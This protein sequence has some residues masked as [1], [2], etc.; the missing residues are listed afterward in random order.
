MQE[1]S[2]QII[3]GK[4]LAARVQEEVAAQV[5]DFKERHGRSPGL[6]VVLVGDDPASSVYVGRKEKSSKAAGIVGR[7]IRMPDTTTREELR[8]QLEALN[9]D[10]NVDGILLQL[11]LPAHIDTDEMLSLIDP[12]KDVDGFHPI[13]QGRLMVGKETFVPCT[14]S[15]MSRMLDEIGADLK[16]KRAVVVGRSNIV[17]KPMAMLLLA[18]HATVTICH[19]R[20]QDLPGEVG[21]ADIV[22]AA[23][24][25]AEFVK[26]EWIK[27]GAIVLD[28]GIN[29]NEAGKLVGDVEFSAAKERAAWITPVPGGVGPMTVA[30]LL[31]NTVQA[32]NQRAGG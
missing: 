17:G 25:R 13:S 15:G 10:D 21:R 12:A 14:P 22:V 31:Q 4:A 5:A 1:A 16:G 8:A 32:A 30:C 24:G 20:T 23:I 9:A 28:V 29:R 2:A 3:D 27:P 19:S 11:P 26:G 6:T 7:T 18:R